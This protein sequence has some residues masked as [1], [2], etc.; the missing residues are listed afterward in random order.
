MPINRVPVIECSE[1]YLLAENIRN[2]QGTLL[3]SEGAKITTF[4]KD[5]LISLGILTVKTYCLKR[6]LPNKK[7]ASYEKV[8]VNY[9]D[10]LESYKSVIHNLSAGRKLE[11][12]KILGIYEQ[13][14]TNIDEGRNLI[15][16][17]NEI[18]SVDEYTY[19]HSINTSIYC[20]LIAKWMGLNDR[21]IK[22]AVQSG[23]L[24]D[25]G[26]VK[27]PKEILN[28]EG[29]LTGEEFA[30]IKKHTIYG[31]EL[32][33]N[34]DEMDVEVKRSVLM[35]HERED[36]SGYPYKTSADFLSLYSKITA[37]ADVYDAI[38]SDRIYKKKKTPFDAFF[39][40]GTS[41]IGI[42][43]TNALSTFL[44]NIIYYFTGSRVLL[45]NG[46]EGRVVHI[47]LHFPHKPI[48]EAN[49]EL[50]DLSQTND[51]EIINILE[52]E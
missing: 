17:I 45:S 24:H 42:F 37:V 38:T 30:I 14:H 22:I 44:S 25:I 20:M 50:I 29:M 52:I 21:D 13:I 49:G 47:P 8:K 35:H 36:G 40:L 43:D 39:I 1:E 19:T 10:S 6:S 18:Q 31:F 28:K 33:K 32:L 7:E 26:K 15:R 41:G 27:V 12:D 4:L 23:L 34:I 9:T 11:Y 51:L 2:S 46:E 3:A 48:I 16:Y 5:K